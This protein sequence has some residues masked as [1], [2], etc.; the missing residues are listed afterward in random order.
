MFNNN[1]TDDNIKNCFEKSFTNFFHYTYLL[2]CCYKFFI[3]H[4]ISILLFDNI[5]QESLF[6]GGLKFIYEN[7]KP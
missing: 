4:M 3:N 6:L 5:L 2:Y 1:Y 7:I